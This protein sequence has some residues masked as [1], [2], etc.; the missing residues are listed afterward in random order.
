M[1]VN[2]AEKSAIDMHRS[3]FTALEQEV[4]TLR[5]FKAGIELAEKEEKL[6]SYSTVLSDEEMTS[7]KEN[8]SKFSS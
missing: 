2:Q 5:E 7:I 3:N 8:I 6:T 1:F 4:V